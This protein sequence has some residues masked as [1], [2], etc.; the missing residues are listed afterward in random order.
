MVI[1]EAWSKKS[2]RMN[3]GAFP[4]RVR[5]S[6]AALPKLPIGPDAALVMLMLNTSGA[7]TPKSCSTPLKWFINGRRPDLMAA[8]MSPLTEDGRSGVHVKSERLVTSKGFS[9]T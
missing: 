6:V 7:K 2:T 5:H 3:V 8:E 1:A 9:N 4:Y